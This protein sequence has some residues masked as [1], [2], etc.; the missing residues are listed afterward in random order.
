MQPS[1][2][3][4]RDA[5]V[6]AALLALLLVAG[7]LNGGSLQSGKPARDRAPPSP[8]AAPRRR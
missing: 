4:L 1:R 6:V 7:R 2:F 8:P 3:R 5:T